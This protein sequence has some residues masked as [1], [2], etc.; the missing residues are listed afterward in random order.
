[1][2]ERIETEAVGG[3]GEAGLVGDPGNKGLRLGS[4][5]LMGNVI[6]GLSAV[7]PAY[8]LAATLGYV[9]DSVHDKAPAMFVLAFIPMLLVAFAY[10]ELS[11]DTPDCG[12]TFTWGTK[13]FGPWVGWI[14]GWGLAVS[15]IIVLANVSEIAALYLFKFLG[16]H[17]L[18]DSLL[19]KI[20]LGSFFIIAMTWISIRGIVISER[21]QA[22]LMFVQFAVLIIASVIALVKVGTGRAG[23]QAVTPEWSWLWPSGLDQSQIAAA[24]ILCIFIYWGWDACLAIS[25]E[26]KDPD[27]TPG[28][29]ALLTC[30]ILVATYVLVAYAV[31]SFA[32][33]GDTGIGLGND[34]NDEDVLTILGDPVAGAVMSSAL[35][36]TVCV[37]A[38]SST[39]ST[40]L[41][42]ARGS[43]S[44]AVY[45]ALPEK[46][47]SIHPRYMTP[48][49]GTG[50]MGAAALTFY[51]VLSLLSQDT[52]ADSI[53]SLGL[54]V[55]FYYGITA[56]ACVWYFRSSLFASARNF[57]LRGLFPLLG[58]LAMAA[59]FIRSAIDMISP[60]YGATSVGGIGGVFVLG[61]GMLVLGIP[62]MLAC[63]A[64]NSDFFRGK[65]LT[66][67]TEVKVPDVY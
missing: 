60:D 61:V 45:K 42:T 57:L 31:Q 44:M 29:A 9:V 41:P 46:F 51:L 33:F 28:R 11:R 23:E 39:Q 20:L 3:G 59:A 24:I 32:G 65:T 52:L 40:I 19:A 56:F 54:A 62:L 64:H 34:A 22:I 55:A 21:M 47:A 27:K 36:L 67:T 37:S 13:A 63:F 43:L 5:G 50:V 14:G 17:G 26:T 7:A 58:G 53:A 12:T 8:S 2:A 4:I 10:R 49:F 30:V 35:L 38:L 6:I 66:A 25:E 1:M 15:A 18:A 16:L 48:A